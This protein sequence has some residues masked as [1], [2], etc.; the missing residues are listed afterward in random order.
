MIIGGEKM[1][2]RKRFVIFSIILGTVPVIILTSIFAINFKVKSIEMIKQ[3]IITASSDQSIN[4]EN[5]F[6]E[7]INDL[8]VVGNIPITKSLL[9]DY[10]NK[11][12]SKDTKYNS[13]ILNQL[14]SSKKSEQYSLSGEALIGKNGIVIASSDNKYTNKKITIS[15]EDAEKLKQGEVVI[16][17]IL[18]REDFNNGIKSIVL[19]SPIFLENQYQGSL[20]SIIDIGYFEKLIKDIHLFKTGKIAIMDSSGQIVASSSNEVTTNINE[21][22]VPNTLY[23]QWEKIDFDSN[24]NGIIEYNIN[25]IDKIGY[26]SSIKNT[27][28][29][30]LSGV[31]WDEFKSP[32]YKNIKDIIIFLIFILVLIVASYTFTIKYFSKPIYDLLESIRKI[33]Q[34]DYKDRFIYDKDNEFGEIAKAFNGLI[35]KIEKNKQY[36]ENKNKDL[37]S[38]ISNIPGGVHRNIIKNG[39]HEL[40]FISGG[41][42]NLLGYERHEFNEVFGKEILDV[43]YEKDRERVEKEIKEQV[44]KFNKFNVEYRIKRKDGSIIWLLDNG[45]IVN[46]RDGK[47]FSY[48]VVINI[49]DAKIAQEELKLNE[50]RYRIIMS[51][52]EDIIFEWNIETDIV[53]FSENWKSKFNYHSTIDDI[54]KKF[55]ESDMIYED[56]IKKFGKILNNIINGKTYQETEIRF[57]TNNDK[58]IWCKI[59]I[60]AMFDENGN[61]FKAMGAIIDIDKEKK[62][63]EALLFKAQRDSLT[64]L[65][66]K[67]TVQSI[68]EDYIESKD[69]NANGALFVIDVD[70]FKGVN[71]NLGHLAGDF[72][73]ASISSMLSKVFDE[74]S[75][76]GRIGGDEFIVF[77]KNIDSEELLYKKADEL[78]KGFRSKFEDE[79]SE[80]KVSGSIGIAKYP[81][82]G[83]SF[84]ELFINADKAVYLA[85]NKGKDNYCVFE[86]I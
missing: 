74:N 13:Y 17:D 61:I 80:Y 86:D 5:F 50:E 82:H 37:Q 32:I 65:Y 75:I 53:H 27:G 67:G 78:V 64:G 45:N 70:N 41:C 26:Y 56:D 1:N 11:V 36:I 79:S 49:T 63:A 12:N 71:D 19:A 44:R 34:G 39:E 83:E 4:L 7:S 73:L 16:T 33:K 76:V 54:S 48:S 42:L 69:A 8:D 66:N 9:N 31:E 55:Y 85:K 51:Q 38:L 30:V 43:I 10:N 52:T 28:W 84:K 68:I 57:R 77:L 29:I 3:N 15:N 20:I 22:N 21:I 6:K 58:Y 81:E 40:D 60:T 23:E 62:E 59:R 25:G 24:P 14:L 46:G 18:E 2:I 47:I 35:D 72:V